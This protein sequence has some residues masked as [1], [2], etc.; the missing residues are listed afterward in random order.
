[1]KLFCTL[2]VAGLTA[3]PLFTTASSLDWPEFR[4]P[5]GQGLSTATNVPIHWS[6]TSN[7]V[8]K[9][10]LPGEGWS[11]PVL[12]NGRLYL[13][14]ALESPVHAL[15]VMC[16][17]AQTGKMVWDREAIQPDEKAAK[18]MHAKNSLASPTCLVRDGRIYAHFGHM[19]TVALDLEGKIL[20]RQ[21]SLSYAPN[22]GNGGTLVW[23]DGLLVYSADGKAD[24]FIAA[25]EADTGKVRW[26]VPRKSDAGNKFSFSTP[27]VIE[28]DGAKQVIS[29][30]SGMVGGFDP[31][32][33]REIWRVRYGQGYSVVPRPVYAQGLL[34]LS[35]GF[36]Q[37]VM[38]AIKPAGAR[39]DVTDT[40]VAWTLTKN[41]PTTPSPL[42]VGNDLYIISD[43]G[44]ASCID[45]PSGKVLWTQRIGGATSASP[46][47]A[48]G[49][50]Y[51][52]NER[53]LGS[54]IKAGRTYELLAQNNLE[55]QS[56]ASYAVSDNT[57]Y[58][59]TKTALWK[60][61]Q[62]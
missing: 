24:P 59:R 23:V 4:G 11:S 58:I 47:H 44:T 19:G 6:T 43:G 40:H 41:G 2:L 56:L 17:D 36:D 39:G 20:W 34:I 27:L 3:T 25:L 10:A 55:D 9:T 12:S 28:V 1:M 29:A 61:G 8:W 51:F 54:V 45:I 53:G 22:H 42:A 33:G 26:K 48:E 30:G 38:Y 35:S 32:D 13:T 18:E 15:H 14:A 16:V 60:I 21:T 37:P 46:V 57:L 62:P 7:V 52:Q 49:R 5:T 50:I 31:K